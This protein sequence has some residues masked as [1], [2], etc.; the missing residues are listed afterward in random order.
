MSTEYF[1]FNIDLVKLMDRFSKKPFPDLESAINKG[2][3]DGWKDFRD[4]AEL[5]LAEILTDYGL[6]GTGIPKQIKTEILDNGVSIQLT[7]SGGGNAQDYAVFVEFGTGVVGEGNQHPKAGEFGWEYDINGH[8]DAGWWYPTDAGD[9]NPTTK[10]SKN[11]WVAFTRG[12]ASRPFMYDLW[13][14]STQS[15]TNIVNKNIRA[16]FRRLERDWK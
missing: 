8:G 4:Q 16:E 12:Q 15:V 11:G 9:P 10:L 2:L 3:D 6:L 1:N 5:K 13:L 7:G 14:W